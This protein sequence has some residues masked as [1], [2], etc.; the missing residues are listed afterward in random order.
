MDGQTDG[1]R[2]MAACTVLC[3][4][5]MMLMRMMIAV[6]TANISHH[7]IYVYFSH[8][9]SSEICVIKYEIMLFNLSFTP[10]MSLHK[11]HTHKSPQCI[12]HSTLTLYLI[13]PLSHINTQIM[14]KAL[15][16]TQTLH[17]GCSKVEPKIFAPPQTP[18]PGAQDGQN[19]I[20]WRW[21]LPS[22]TDPVW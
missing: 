2:P 19:V 22:P 10:R 21:S 9:V 1:R 3:I 11:H 15:R 16:E 12:Y 4:I 13:H 17:A 18:F 14:K 7:Y 5:I 6:I 20:S 8:I